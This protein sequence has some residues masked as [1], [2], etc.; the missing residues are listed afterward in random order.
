MNFIAVC[1]EEE[2]G[3]GTPRDPI[4]LVDREGSKRLVQPKTGKDVT[5]E[6]IIYSENQSAKFGSKIDGFILK[7]RSPSCGN[8]SHGF[9]SASGIHRDPTPSCWMHGQTE[10]GCRCWA[11]S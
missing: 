8:T 7:D 9:Q 5:D 3:L 6:M 1:P 11:Q 4:R 10:R 2:I